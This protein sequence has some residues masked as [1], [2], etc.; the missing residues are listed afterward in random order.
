MKKI[1]VI[2]DEE[3]L[4]KSFSILLEKNGYEVLTTKSSEDAQ[5]IAEEEDFNL[6][7]CDIR[8]PGMNGV[9]IIRSIRSS[10]R[11]RSISSDTPVI[12]VTGYADAG[13]E[14]EARALE[15]VAYVLKPFDSSKL[16][17]LVKSGCN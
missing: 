1:L 4:T 3:I 14:R 7:I 13:V 15:P 17:E 2:D 9:E 12:F 16:L 11:Q 5:V 8:M 10:S 6:I